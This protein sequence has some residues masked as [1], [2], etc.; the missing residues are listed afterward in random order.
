MADKLPATRVSIH[1]D[2][3]CSGN[4]GPGGW[5]AV[6]LWKDTELRLSGGEK[7]TMNNRM[8]LMAA[9]QALEALK[10]PCAV[11]L[12]SDSSYLVNA[13]TQGW[14]DRWRAHGWQ[15]ADKK[16]VANVD[17]WLRLI[18]AAEIHRITW[19]KTKGHSGDKYND[20]CDALA[21]AETAKQKDSHKKS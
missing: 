11:A 12:Y 2:G 20:I 7:N 16:P 14:I 8:E 3:A 9:I 18:A 6:L 5:A 15:R 21:V 17:L 13:F 1:T 4:P 19:Y 10:R